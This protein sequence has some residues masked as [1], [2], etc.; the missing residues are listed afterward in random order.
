MTL[1]DLW[2]LIK[3]SVWLVIGLPI[4]CAIV[5]VAVLYFMPNEY[6][7]TSTITASAE[8]AGVGS[9]ATA[10][11]EQQSKNGVEVKASTNTSTRVI[12]ITAEGNDP[13]QC[14]KAANR[15]L[16]TTFIK[17]FSRYNVSGEVVNIT[18]RMDLKRA[19]AATDESP[20]TTK[21]AGIAL[22]AGLFAAVCIVVIMDL[23]RGN[24]HSARDMEEDYEAQLL[25]RI[26]KPNQQEKALDRQ[27]LFA[28]VRFASGEHKSVCVLSIDNEALS[29][30]TC[31]ELAEAATQA[32]KRVLLVD[33]DMNGQS[34]LAENLVSDGNGLSD[35]LTGEIQL[36]D[37]VR[38]TQG[39]S[40]VP[41]GNPKQSPIALLDSPKLSQ[42]LEQAQL[43]YDIVI[44]NAA[45]T[46]KQADF[47]Y[48]ANV[49][50]STILC[51]QEFVTKRKGIEAAATQLAIAKANVIGFVA[52]E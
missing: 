41:A 31:T 48:V 3:R 13:N 12:T 30:Q 36:S 25:G 50:G 49:A 47:S 32:D 51:V 52:A 10:A 22:L 6:S 17:A 8:P 2:K 44:L 20:S 14:I 19:T 5:C 23:V 11:A 33:A 39:F 28:N 40:Y 29:A 35:V 46:T 15:A 7:A 16:N 18:V 9:F 26:P 4:V 21:S 45:P 43:E 27:Q 38:I 37:A 1:L 34:Q 24:I 42:M